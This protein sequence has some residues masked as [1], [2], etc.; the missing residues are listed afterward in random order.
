MES[1]KGGGYVDELICKTETDLQTL[2]TF[3]LPKG[4]E[5]GSGLGVSDWHMHSEVNGL[6]GQWEPAK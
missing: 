1:K 2:K 5:W 3:W 4:D 6:T